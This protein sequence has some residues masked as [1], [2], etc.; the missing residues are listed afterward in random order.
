M[1][2]PIAHVDDV[3]PTCAHFPS[4]I[5]NGVKHETLVAV[6][7]HAL[8]Q[9]MDRL[10]LELNP[11]IAAGVRR[12]EPRRTALNFHSLQQDKHLRCLAEHGWRGR[13]QQNIKF[14]ILL[15]SVACFQT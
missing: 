6:L 13:Q 14:F 5:R 3:A 8:S 12:G 9:E 7:H 10:D 11:R 15:K 4:F 1:V 2:Q